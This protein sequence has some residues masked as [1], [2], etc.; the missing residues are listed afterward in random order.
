MNTYNTAQKYPD[1]YLFFIRFFTDDSIT[2]LQI[3]EFI[4]IRYILCNRYIYINIT[5]INITFINITFTISNLFL[6]ICNNV[7]FLNYI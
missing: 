4:M 2:K 1:T 6:K 7:N 3:K 5:F